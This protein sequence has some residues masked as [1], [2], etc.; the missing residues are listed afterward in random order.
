MQSDCSQ[1]R[2]KIKSLAWAGFSLCLWYLYCSGDSAKI[3]VSGARNKYLAGF[4]NIAFEIFSHL[5]LLT[6][7]A[8]ARSF[9]FYVQVEVVSSTISSCI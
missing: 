9:R 5:H 4:M 3:P 6:P 8:G 1:L 7:C 2:L